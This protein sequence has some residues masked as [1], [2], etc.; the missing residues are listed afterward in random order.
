M[1]NRGSS[2]RDETEML[3]RILT[4]PGAES[5]RQFVREHLNLRPDESV[6]SIGCGPGFEPATLAAD[7]SERGRVLGLD[8]NSETLAIARD[9][10]A[11]LPQVSFGQ[12]D[13]AELPVP[14]DSF[15]VAVAKQ[16]YQFVPDIDRA[17]R[18]L[19]R[20]LKP[21]GRA[22]VVSKDLDAWVLH[23]SDRR[24]MQRAKEVYRRA[25]LHPHLGSRLIAR[26]PAAGLVVEDIEPKPV[27]HTEINAQVE[28]GIEVHRKFLEADES[29][30]QSELEAWEQDLRELDEAGE[31][32]SC[33]TQFLYIARRPE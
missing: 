7:I 21:G 14:D 3:E 13:A 27:L 24:R 11:D 12:G 18:E 15:D 2:S 10:C 26:L 9:R 20:V 32:F 22:A 23:S 4:T 16:V 1:S 17:L 30:D 6:L 25:L 5:L 28:R 31:F 8:V 29:F 33:G 19:Q